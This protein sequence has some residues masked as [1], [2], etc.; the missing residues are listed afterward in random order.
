[1][2]GGAAPLALRRDCR[3]AAG[4][5]ADSGGC[6]VPGEWVVCQRTPAAQAAPRVNEKAGVRRRVRPAWIQTPAQD[7]RQARQPGAGLPRGERRHR[8]PDRLRPLPAVHR[9]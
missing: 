8:A 1:V 5:R 3:R 6:A 7:G 4:G 9:L 2:P